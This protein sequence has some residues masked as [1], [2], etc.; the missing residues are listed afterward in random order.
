MTHPITMSD[1]QSDDFES[2]LKSLDLV[3]KLGRWLIAGAFGLGVWVSTIQIQV[4][5]N[6]INSQRGET[7]IRDLELK[8]S[9]SSERL[10]SAL[11]ILERIDRKLNP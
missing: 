10:A 2:R 8:E 3:V 7:R 11:K 6:T 1:D 4:N 5:L 9:V